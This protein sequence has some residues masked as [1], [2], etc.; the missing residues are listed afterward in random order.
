MLNRRCLIINRDAD[1]NLTEMLIFIQTPATE[2]RREMATMSEKEME[3]FN[4]PCISS[5]NRVCDD[6]TMAITAQ[7]LC[8]FQ[9]PTVSLPFFIG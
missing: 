9:L 3:I 8:D 2:R 7:K 5:G 4:L 1:Q 6:C